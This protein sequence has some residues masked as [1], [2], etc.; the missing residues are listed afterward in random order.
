M[1]PPAHHTRSQPVSRHLIAGLLATI[2]AG[3]FAA[4]ADGVNDQLITILK[5]RTAGDL[6]G[7][8]LAT[9]LDSKPELKPARSNQLFHELL[10]KGISPAAIA[11]LDAILG[12]GAPDSAPVRLGAPP[13]DQDAIVLPPQRA[14]RR[15]RQ[16]G[17]IPIKE[18]EKPKLLS[19]AQKVVKDK[20]NPRLEEPGPGSTVRQAER[21]RRVQEQKE[22]WLENVVK[23]NSAAEPLL[24]KRL[25]ASDKEFADFKAAALQ[26]TPAT[27]PGPTTNTTTQPARDPIFKL[28]F[29]SGAKLQN[30]YSIGIDTNHVGTLAKDNTSTD[31][32]IEARTSLRYVT[33]QVVLVDEPKNGFVS[34]FPWDLGPNIKK[35]AMPDVE[36]SFGYIFSGQSSPTNYSASSVVGGS[37]LYGELSL[38]LPW[39]RYRSL[40]KS[41]AFQATL[42]LS[43]GFVTDKHFLTVHPSMFAGGGFQLSDLTSNGRPWYWMGRL[44]VAR[45][46]TPKL[47]GM[48]SQVAL[49]NLDIPKF[50]AS[51]APTF[52]T[53]II[54]PLSEGW[55]VQVGGNAY[56]TDVP[57]SWNISVGFIIDPTAFFP[58]N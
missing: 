39:Y 54:I 17:E 50:D 22:T 24:S 53:S 42:E 34:P 13:R 29:L 2:S 7:R 8:G 57:A 33:R 52:G 31:G 3:C 23:L 27:D 51:W 38:G 15:S 9:L 30:P 43:G 49:D 58:K 18:G 12:G 4:A 14:S 28:W 47:T 46:D 36:A 48:G 41:T 32:F 37:D 20:D 5:L 19:L 10:D 16:D 55:S 44:G 25:Q 56:L 1:K 11:D 45:T 26:S 6:N 35:V 21:M 40:D